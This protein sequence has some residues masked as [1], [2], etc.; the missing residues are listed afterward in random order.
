MRIFAQRKPAQRRLKQSDKHRTSILLSDARTACTRASGQTCAGGSEASGPISG[1]RLVPFPGRWWRRILPGMD[2]PEKRRWY[3]PTS[4]WLVLGSLAVTGLLWLSNWLGWWHKGYA[5]L[6]AVAAVGVVLASMLLWWLVALVL[7]R[8]FQF[9]LRTLLALVVVVALPCSW[10]AVEMRKARQQQAAVD[11]MEAS[12]TF[13]IYSEEPDDEGWHA[14]LASGPLDRLFGGCFFYTVITTWRDKMPNTSGHF[15]SKYVTREGTSSILLALKNLP[16]L[17]ALRPSSM[18]I[19]DSDLEHVIPLKTLKYL[20][21]TATK[22][23]DEGV[24]KLQQSL[25]NCK[26][27]R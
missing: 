24:A 15:V 18:P 12:D 17:R 27:T 22:V 21:L 20:D 25:P 10:L 23:T 4:G 1:L 7:R 5:V 3:R 26:I 8:R 13:V 6:V 16:D 2:A 9:G 19:D 11:L 14:P